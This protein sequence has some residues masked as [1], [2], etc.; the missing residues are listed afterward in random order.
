MS[1]LNR[2]I[3]HDQSLGGDPIGYR[4]DA[5]FQIQQIILDDWERDGLKPT[6]T[7]CIE[8]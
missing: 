5:V 7:D 6:L 3:G 4:G 8:L 1:Y 2:I